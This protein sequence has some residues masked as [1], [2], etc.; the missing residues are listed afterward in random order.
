MEKRFAHRYHPFIEFLRLE[1]RYSPHTI[2]AYEDDLESFFCFLE[3]TYDTLPEEIPAEAIR[4]W[5]AALKGNGISSRSIN[6]KLST[7]RS[8]GKYRLRQGFILSDPARRIP[9]PRSGKRLPDFV[10]L[11]AMAKLG[12]REP[13][14]DNFEGHTQYLIINLLYTTGIRR[15]ELIHLTS[16]SLD[17]AASTLKVMGKGGKERI[18]PLSPALLEQIDLYREEKNNLPDADYYFLLITPSGRPLYPEYVYR[19]VKRYL[20]LVTTLK[21]KG[22]HILRHT[23]A[24][25]LV[26]SGADLN[27]IKELLGHASLAATQVYTHNTIEQL[28]D[29]HSQAHPR[30]GK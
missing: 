24:T 28:K 22:P 11:S 30:S 6:R 5:M 2:R 26:N 13:F 21:R 3:A 18:I 25:H 15:S 23:F 12:N 20:G 29:I 7:L 19:T 9:A 27:A 17:H 4:S 1:K 16:R 10:D 14:P 8:W